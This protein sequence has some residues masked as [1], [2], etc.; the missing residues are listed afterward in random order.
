[1]K[2]LRNSVQGKWNRFVPALF[3]VFAI[4]GFIGTI[5]FFPLDLA[6]NATCLYEVINQGG[7]PVP[8]DLVQAVHGA[9]PTKGASELSAEELTMRVN[10]IRLHNYMDGYLLWWW[11]SM[12]LLIIGITKLYRRRVLRKQ[13]ESVSHNPKMGNQI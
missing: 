4:V 1:M 6:N 2:S 11:G 10:F 5:L 7:Q 13:S 8:V 9:V 3:W 12:G